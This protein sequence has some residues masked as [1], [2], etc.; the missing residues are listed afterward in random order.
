MGLPLTHF[1]L[2]FLMMLSFVANGATPLAT[3]PAKPESMT[4]SAAI[5]KAGRQRMLSQR[6]VKA[7]CQV[8]LKVRADKSRAI[9]DKSVNLFDAQLA[10]LRQF[11][12]KPEILEAL[13]KEAALWGEMRA[14]A[15]DPVNRDGAKKLMELNEALLQAAHKVTMLLETAAGTK[16][17]R[18]VNIAGRQRMLSQRLAKFYMLKKWG[19]NSTEITSGIEQAKKEFVSAMQE[20]SAAPQNTPEIQHEL[21]QVKTQWVFFEN[22]LGQ[23]DDTGEDLMFATNVATTSERILEAMDKVTALY[24]KVGGN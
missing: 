16:S 11:A 5:N 9:L 19:F 22:A 1:A 3:P 13:A 4:L 21:E 2:P 23:H 18:L 24:E 7:Y 14:V 6:I 15:T 8:G 10:E 12:G 17:G 20:L